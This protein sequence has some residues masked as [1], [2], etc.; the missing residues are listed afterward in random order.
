MTYT[1]SLNDENFQLT[2]RVIVLAHVDCAIEFQQRNGIVRFSG[3]VDTIGS[4]QFEELHG[5]G[6]PLEDFDPQG[7]LGAQIGEA[8]SSKKCARGRRRLEKE[9]CR[10]T[11]T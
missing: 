6:G 9:C 11:R 10:G 1:G 5:P 2:S 8:N 4:A 7:A 3:Y